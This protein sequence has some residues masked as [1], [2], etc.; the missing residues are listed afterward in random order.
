MP[1]APLT[2]GQLMLWCNSLAA[3]EPARAALNLRQVV[4]VPDGVDLAGVRA[5]LAECVRRH[6]ALRTTIRT[7]E[8][9]DPH[10]VIHPPAGPPLRVVPAE[11]H[12]VPSRVREVAAELGRVPV[13]LDTEWPL[14]AAVVTEAGR[15]RTL[16]LMVHHIAADAR[17]LDLLATQL[18][19]G[20]AAA[21]AGVTAPLPAV[22]QPRD[23][24][25]QER[26][27]AEQARAAAAMTYWAERL[28]TI[29]TTLFPYRPDPAH[30]GRVRVDLRS[31]ALAAALPV[32]TRGLGLPASAVL[33]AAVT[34]V[35][36]RYTGNDRWS[37]TTV[38]DNRPTTGYESSVGSFIQLGLVDVDAAG[39]GAFSLLARS[40]WRAQLV[41]ARHSGYDHAEM[42]EQ[43]AL[44]TGE[45]RTAVTLPTIF[46]FKP[47]ARRSPGR[48][49]DA[50]TLDGDLL[51]RTETTRGPGKGKPD[52]TLFA[53]VDE[54]TEVAL[55]SFDAD[56]A[57]L[58]ADDLAELLRA[59]ERL[60]WRAAEG[61]DPAPS[62]LGVA[63]RTTDWLRTA[64]G[65]VLDLAGTERLL[66]EHPGVEDAAVT[67]ASDGA[68]VATVRAA[69]PPSA[70]L[71]HVASALDTPGVVLP[72]AVRLV[73][74]LPEPPARPDT[75]AEQALLAALRERAGLA[76][77]V[78]GRSYAEQGGRARRVP[79]V[80]D[81]LAELGFT[82]VT[83]PDLLGP[84]PLRSVASALRTTAD[85]RLPHG[86]DRRSGTGHAGPQAGAGRPR[87]A[88]RDPAREIRQ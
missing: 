45:R 11:P 43:R 3:P 81:R 62:D 56:A 79:A 67:V 55:L 71:E 84:R 76:G 24:A 73:G 87:A 34:A 51:G 66:R 17:T 78:L 5:V 57:I 22:R 21:A 50:G 68:V 23:L 88:G 49:E 48:R 75:E 36:M 28:R 32:V 47:T 82:G 39:T 40:C 30:P 7:D 54:I 44:A 27:P 35:L 41:A 19:D 38:V 8:H 12:D 1:H 20:L 26:T 61:D 83:F 29:P 52:T 65:R 85:R 15:P 80:L 69:I 18:G 70:V 42:L 72:D 6:E 53:V 59:A 10:Q 74:G 37:W 63:V 31:P 46:N 9:G 77:A 2:R 58:P 14:R 86:V 4:P 25:E 16:C 64:D 33:M 60:V 13:R